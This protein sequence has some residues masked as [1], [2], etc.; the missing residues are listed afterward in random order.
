MGYKIL[1]INPG[2][3]STKVAVFEN[4]VETHSAEAMHDHSVLA[5]LT[6]LDEQL[7]YR[8]QT[9]VETLSEN[10]IDLAGL[11]AVACRGG[12]FGRIHGGAYKVEENLLYAC[13]HPY[14]EH[15]SNYAAILGYAFAQDYGCDAYIYDAVCTDEIADVARI[16]GFK[17]ITRTGFSHTLNTKAVARAEAAKMGINYEDGNFIVVHMGGGCSTNIQVGGKIIETISDDEGAFSLERAG[18]MATRFIISECFSGKYTQKE[19][20]KKTK[21][22]GGIVSL[23]GSKDMREIEK[24]INEGDAE[25][26]MATDAMAYQFARDIGSLVP[27]VKGKVDRIILT[28]GCAHRKFLTDA[29]TEMVDYIAP[30]SVYPGA[31]EMQALNDGISRVLDG[32]EDFRVLESPHTM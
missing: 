28:G 23:I 25:A 2:S 30:V 6:T 9:I 20:M 13:K 14:L 11:S 7:D 26:K 31:L 27:I 5:A 32:T 22:Q 18:R 24:R 16:T 8:R 12:C 10:N 17:E 3:T 19:M 15:A 4:G 29:I 1:V 21:G